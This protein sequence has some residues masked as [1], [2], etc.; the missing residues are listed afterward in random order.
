MKTK[1]Q[2]RV[3]GEHLWAKYDEEFQRWYVE[4]DGQTYSAETL[5]MLVEKLQ[6][7]GKSVTRY[8]KQ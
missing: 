5:E 1:E 4:I 2:I 7:A 8:P 6:A 3:D